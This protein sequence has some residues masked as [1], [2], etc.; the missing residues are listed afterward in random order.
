[1]G[2]PRQQGRGGGALVTALESFCLSWEVARDRFQSCQSSRCLLTYCLK[3]EFL[4]KRRKEMNRD[5]GVSYFKR[6]Q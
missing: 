6:V 4:K 3:T 5:L 1:M 2:Q